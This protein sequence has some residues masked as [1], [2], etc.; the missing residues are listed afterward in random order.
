MFGNAASE[1][2]WQESVAARSAEIEFEFKG[3]KWDDIRIDA[4]GKVT[5]IDA[6]AKYK[7]LHADSKFPALMRK[8]MIE[9]FRDAASNANGLPIEYHCMRQEDADLFNVL[10]QGI[11]GY[12]DL[13]R[14]IVP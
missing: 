5:L 3:K 2:K 10:L 14:V 12:P 6:K 7:I 9:H 11:K 1:F 13:I 8:K 4:A